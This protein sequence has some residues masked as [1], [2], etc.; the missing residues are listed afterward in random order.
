[1]IRL[2]KPAFT[3]LSKLKSRDENEDILWL[4]IKID[5]ERIIR[6]FKFI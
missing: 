6:F 4:K 3:F 5:V 1:M 2:S